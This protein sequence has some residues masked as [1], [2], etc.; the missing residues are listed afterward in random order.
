MISNQTQSQPRV[1]FLDGIK[2]KKKKERPWNTL[3]SQNSGFLCE[4]LRWSSLIF[5]STQGSWL[6][7][8]RAETEGPLL[9]K[10]LESLREEERASETSELFFFWDFVANRM[11]FGPWRHLY[12]S[13]KQPEVLKCFL[14][15]VRLGACL[16]FRNSRGW[17][18][19]IAVSSR[20]AW[21]MLPS[22]H[23]S[24]WINDK[25]TK[26]LIIEIYVLR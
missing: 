23:V 16:W 4:A 8:L 10:L 24:E 17:G 26:S 19:K 9:H 22:Y 1:G 18:R 11:E 12:F 3:V 2:K 6:K 21:V 20:P 15:P 13:V 7:L 5:K 25:Q 14:L